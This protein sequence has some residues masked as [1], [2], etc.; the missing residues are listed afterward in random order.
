MNDTPLQDF[1]ALPAER[2][3]IPHRHLMIPPWGSSESCPY[4]SRQVQALISPTCEIPHMM[5]LS[6]SP[7]TPALSQ[8]PSPSPTPA[9]PM[10]PLDA[11]KRLQN[12]MEIS[13]PALTPPLDEE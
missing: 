1:W 11:L 7:T 8:S 4:S 3:V 12:P 5:S 2:E 6:R 10:S 13:A 9:T